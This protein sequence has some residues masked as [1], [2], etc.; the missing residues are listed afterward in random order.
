MRGATAFALCFYISDKFQSTHPMRGATCNIGVKNVTTQFQ[1]THPM[2][3]ATVPRP[4]SGDGRGY[5]NPR[6]PCEVRQYMK[7]RWIHIQTF[8]STHPMRGA[9]GFSYIPVQQ[10]YH[11]NPRTPCEVR[12]TTARD[13]RY[14]AI[15]SIHAP[16]ARCDLTSD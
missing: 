16:H 8:Q 4:L 11:F 13:I 5:F 6:T 7:T 14:I 9:T 12:P 2:R 15:I 1:S 3:G 10:G